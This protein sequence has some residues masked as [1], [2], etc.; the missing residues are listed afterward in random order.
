MRL[1]IGTEVVGIGNENEDRD[2]NLRAPRDPVT[3]PRRGRRLSEPYRPAH[4]AS[5][6]I[7]LDVVL[8]YDTTVHQTDIPFEAELTAEVRLKTLQR[9]SGREE[10]VIAFK[11]HILEIPQ[12]E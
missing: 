12:S 11:M 10:A 3:P 5:P 8:T 4:A 7:P 2:R 1:L 9:F 6:V